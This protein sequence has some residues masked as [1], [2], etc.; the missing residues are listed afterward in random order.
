M[1]SPK[2]S[3]SVSEEVKDMS[4]PIAS[5]SASTPSV[6]AKETLKE[7]APVNNISIAEPGKVVSSKPV[8]KL[9]PSVASRENK[10][11]PTSKITSQPQPNSIASTQKSS[12]LQQSVSTPKSAS[13]TV[14]FFL[15]FVLNSC[16]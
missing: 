12:A 3:S 15:P 5:K 1:T 10:K 14:S 8:S 11:E 4:S 16:F 13:E 9:A 2:N 7:S 6:D